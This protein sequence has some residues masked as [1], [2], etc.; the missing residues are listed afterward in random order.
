MLKLDDVDI[1]ILEILQKEGRIAILPLA[2]RVGLSPAP[3][4]RRVKQLEDAGIIERYMAVLNPKCLGLEL[5]VYVEV[6]LN[7]SSQ[8]ANENFERAIRAMPEV[9]EA[10]LVTGNH[11]YLLHL[12]LENTDKLKDFLRDRFLRLPNIGQ[13]LSSIVLEGIKRTTAISLPRAATPTTSK[14]NGPTLR[15]SRQSRRRRNSQGEKD[16]AG[17]GQQN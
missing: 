2:E 1:K 6:R 17:S 3:C 14:K 7:S 16:E 11:D 12:R 10:Y 13:T 4:S 15:S 9:V 8:E 5:D